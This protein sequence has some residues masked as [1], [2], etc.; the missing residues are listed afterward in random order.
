MMP[1]DPHLRILHDTERKQAPADT[2]KESPN[3]RHCASGPAAFGGQPGCEASGE[4]QGII[5]GK[6]LAFSLGFSRLSWARSHQTFVNPS[7]AG[8]ACSIYSYKPLRRV[9]VQGRHAPGAGLGA[10]SAQR[11]P[12][13]S[14]LSVLEYR[15]INTGRLYVKALRFWQKTGIIN[16]SEVRERGRF[17]WA[18]KKNTSAGWKCSQTTRKRSRS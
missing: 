2:W 4:S 12:T 10:R 1:L 13:N 6:K 3:C 18:A 15:K 8:G 16:A 9:G 11:I 17:R 7:A 5:P 14:N